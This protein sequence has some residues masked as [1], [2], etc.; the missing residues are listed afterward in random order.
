[1]AMRDEAGRRARTSEP[2][3]TPRRNRFQWSPFE[4][5]K[6]SF[7]HRVTQIFKTSACM[8]SCVMYKRLVRVAGGW[9]D[10]A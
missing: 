9:A 5:K 4:R 6:K 10:L 3:P 8:V 2:N 7:R 1:M